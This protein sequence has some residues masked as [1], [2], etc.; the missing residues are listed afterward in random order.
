MRFT[1]ACTIK[2]QDCKV[3]IILIMIL[4]FLPFSVNVKS[5]GHFFENTF[6]SL[7][8]LYHLANMCTPK[9]S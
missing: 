2:K 3:C 7:R 5:N 6:T 8:H 9:Y 4:K 1:E